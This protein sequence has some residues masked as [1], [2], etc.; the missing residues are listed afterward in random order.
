MGGL[1]R[2]T[3][4]EVMHINIIIIIYYD[5]VNINSILIILLSG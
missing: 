5:I 2:S 1:H 3:A 4:G